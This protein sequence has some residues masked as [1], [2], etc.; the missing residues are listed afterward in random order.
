MSSSI[1]LTGARFTGRLGKLD[2]ALSP[3]WALRDQNGPVP[4]PTGFVYT[5]RK[6][7]DVVITHDGRA[8]A[9]LRGSA[10]KKFLIRVNTRDPQQVMARA[11][12]NHKRGNERRA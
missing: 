1:R 4:D 8:A 12:G 10:A 3:R 11:T 2:L 9:T 5:V 6:N 7:G